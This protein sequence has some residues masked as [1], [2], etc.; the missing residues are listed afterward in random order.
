[1]EN[2]KNNDIDK[3]YNI[4]NN[5]LK[6]LNLKIV[7]T[8]KPQNIVITQ[9][10]ATKK[11]ND[12]DNSNE[13]IL[14]IILNKDI[15]TTPGEKLTAISHLTSKFNDYHSSSF[16][17]LPTDMIYR[18]WLNSY[19]GYGNTVVL[20]ADEET[21]Y[22]NCMAKYDNVDFIKLIEDTD[23]VAHHNWKLKL[24]QHYGFIFFGIKKDMPKW[25]R[26]LK[27]AK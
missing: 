24:P 16:Y 4:A 12:E 7:V 5:V 3:L 13:P 2:K 10:I 11:Y 21:I 27:L 14:Y 17:D 25:I 19:N 20:E 1:M 9:S 18:E 6:D 23:R 15:Y 22:N 8:P 26:Q